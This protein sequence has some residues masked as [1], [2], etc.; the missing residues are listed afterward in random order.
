MIRVCSA[1]SLLSLMAAASIAMADDIIEGKYN[2]SCKMCHEA[3]LMEAPKTG[4]K[5]A[6]A[7]RLTQGN[8]VLLKHTIE[9]YKLMPAKGL[10]QNCSEDDYRKLID[11][12]SGR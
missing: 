7:P 9:G 8:E 11:K 12:M 4:D 3:G 5:E 2:R 6:W 10:C 1:F